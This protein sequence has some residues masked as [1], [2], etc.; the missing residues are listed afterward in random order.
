MWL[1]V[2]GMVLGAVI[3]IFLTALISAGPDWEEP[4]ED[5]KDED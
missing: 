1:F 2:I 3:G 5:K 4:T